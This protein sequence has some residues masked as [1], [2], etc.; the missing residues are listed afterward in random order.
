M[1][2]VALGLVILLAVMV[3]PVGAAWDGACSGAMLLEVAGWVGLEGD[4]WVVPR[5]GLEIVVLGVL[6][7]GAGVDWVV[8]RAGLETAGLGLS[9][10][11]VA[12][13]GW[14]GGGGSLE[15]GLVVVLAVVGGV[16]LLAL[17]LLTLEAVAHNTIFKNK[18]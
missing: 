8:P 16:L 10:G 9:A 14:L 1:L 7:A 6:M 12:C 17:G 13:V 2:A 5:A 15:V 3:T 18:G 4:V 11:G